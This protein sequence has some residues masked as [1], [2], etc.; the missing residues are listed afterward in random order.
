V[1]TSPPGRLPVIVGAVAIVGM[2]V[3][4]ACGGG[5]QA[6]STYLCDIAFGP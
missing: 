6:P 1:F 3:L 5:N 4:T 2:G